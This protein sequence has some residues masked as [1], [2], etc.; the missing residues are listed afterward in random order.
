VRYNSFMASN[1][2]AVLKI[3]GIEPE[4]FWIAFMTTESRNG[5]FMTTSDDLTE[6]E[7]C[8]ELERMGL[9]KGEIDS[10]IQQA[11]QYPV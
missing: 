1:R 5:H 3:K 10:R 6:S 7:V 4:V 2:N 8:A 11:R 9:T